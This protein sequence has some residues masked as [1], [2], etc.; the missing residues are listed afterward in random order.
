MSYGHYRVSDSRYNE[1]YSE[2]GAI[3]ALEILQIIKSHHPHSLGIAAGLRFFQST[4][5]ATLTQEE[6]RLKLHPL[7]FGIRYRLK[8]KY[9]MPWI[10]VGADHYMYEEKSIIHDTDGST[11]G[12]HVQGGIYVPFPGIPSLKLKFYARH[13]KA[14]AKENGLNINLGG[15]EFSLGLAFGFNLF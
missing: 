12:Y 1:V 2:G 4:G 6:T 5:Q 3:Y 15:P 7:T 10:E 13:T 11:W 8:T 9:V 14:T